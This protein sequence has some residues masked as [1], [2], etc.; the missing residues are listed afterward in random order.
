MAIHYRTQ[1][2]I[3]KKRD[4]READRIFTVFTKD[5][6]KLEILGRGIRKI[7]S[8]L[9]GGMQLFSLAEIEFIQGK[10]HKT[11]TDASSIEIFPNLR[12][13]LKRLKI[14]FDISELLDSLVKGPEKEQKIWNLLKST[15]Q[16]LNY[17]SL[18]VKECWLSFYN[19]F[20][21]IFI[22]LGYKP[23]LNYCCICQRKPD[24][25]NLYF[26]FEE[27]GIICL[28]C[29]KKEKEGKEISSNVVKILRLM[30]E[31]E[32]EFLKK[33]KIKEAHKK[34]IKEI[35]QNYLSFIKESLS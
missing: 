34:E 15:F 31:K 21:K 7:K 5:F 14:A 35:S 23:E 29:F 4:F 13:D 1:G 9:R 27:G 17:P 8:K 11:L 10:T 22:I 33:L 20:W 28:N 25:K 3:L 6:G 30:C 12:K 18:S 19:F 2:F 32:I 16:V 26:N 24:P